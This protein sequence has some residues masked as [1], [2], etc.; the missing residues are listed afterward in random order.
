MKIV[1]GKRVIKSQVSV[2]LHRDVI[3]ELDTFVQAQDDLS[4]SEVIEK[5]IM[6]YLN[7]MHDA[8]N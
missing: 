6:V 5:A 3:Q 4:R 1:N 8:G 7:N 2:M